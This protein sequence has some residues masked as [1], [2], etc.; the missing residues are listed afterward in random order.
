MADKQ[1]LKTTSSTMS[2]S[3]YTLN[4]IF[5]FLKKVFDGL[6][7]NLHKSYAHK[8]FDINKQTA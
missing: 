1:A 4:V 3:K 6:T 2:S 5:Y 8:S 7:S